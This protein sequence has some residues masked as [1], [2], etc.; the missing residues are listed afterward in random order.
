MTKIAYIRASQQNPG[1]Q[2]NQAPAS[3]LK[4]PIMPPATVAGRVRQCLGAA[5]L[6]GAF[7]PQPPVA[8]SVA[9]AAL[10]SAPK[11]MLMAP[12]TRFNSN[13]TVVFDDQANGRISKPLME[14]RR[15][16]RINQCLSQLKQIVVDSA[17]QYTE[18]NKCKLEKADILELT[19]KY[20]KKLHYQT[21]DSPTAA[22][23]ADHPMDTSSNQSYLSGF[24][25]CVRQIT[26][27][28]GDISD[29][30]F[31]ESLQSHLNQCLFSI[32]SSESANQCPPPVV[33]VSQSS[34]V[35][36]P[37]PSN[38]SN[39]SSAPFS[40]FCTPPSPAPSAESSLSSSSS[41]A[42][43]SPLTLPHHHHHAQ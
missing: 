18:N 24:S 2:F 41:S 27:F 12:T 3:P 4:S 25:D 10:S 33:S 38:S 31:R 15:R 13:P 7:N 42:S 30:S 9:A 21:V 5:P 23:T 20:V 14:K 11:P 32:Q 17:G 16:A 6:L 36:P 40:T 35:L 1:L 19:V 34:S 43:L 22:S 8:R 26:D 29:V 39:S 37:S 28:V